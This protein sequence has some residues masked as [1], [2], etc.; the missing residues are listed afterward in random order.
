[1]RILVTG[2]AGFIGGHVAEGLALSGHEVIGVDDLSGGFWRNVHPE[3]KFHQVDLRDAAAI[4]QVICGHQPEVLCHLAANAREGASQFQP[5]D[6]CSR[7]LTA[8]INT[9]VPCVS[10]GV[11]KVVLYSSM[12]VYGEQPTPFNEEQPRQPVDIYG[13]NKTAMEEITEILAEVHEFGY[14]I[15]RPHNVFGERQSLRDPFRNVV[16]I[17]MNRIMRGEPLY[18]Y[19]DGE[20]QRAYSYIADSLPAFL[21]ASALDPALDRQIINVGGKEAITVNELVELVAAQFDAKPEVKHLPDRPREVK[22][23]FSTW[24]KSAELLGYDEPFGMREGIRKMAEW[25][26]TLGP[27]PWTEEALELPS[28]KAPAIWMEK[29]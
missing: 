22:Y 13:V 11:K 24:E 27:Q 26:K 10:H 4:E 19:G 16:G 17:F 18:V 7:N 12:A 28:E 1:M 6:V 15:I 8:Y 14:T 3:V 25:A 2:V 20:Q 21:R 29:R 23:A 5:R 9:L